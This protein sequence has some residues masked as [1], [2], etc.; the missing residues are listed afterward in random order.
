MDLQ[1]L[2]KRVGK[3]YMKADKSLKEYVGQ[4]LS[5]EIEIDKD[6]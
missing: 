4:V 1:E 5:G 2:I 6:K 3:K